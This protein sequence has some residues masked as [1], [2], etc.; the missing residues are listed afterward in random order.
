MLPCLSC[1]KMRSILILSIKTDSGIGSQNEFDNKNEA[2]N[3]VRK[4][5][6]IIS[7]VKNGLKVNPSLHKQHEKNGNTSIALAAFSRIRRFGCKQ[8]VSRAFELVFGIIFHFICH[9]CIIGIKIESPVILKGLRKKGYQA[10]ELKDCTQI[11][12]RPRQKSLQMYVF[13]NN[14]KL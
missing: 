1:I 6:L 7:N 5:S 3:L 2:R 11:K 13:F 12:L 9:H 14:Y 8:Y 4:R 10:V